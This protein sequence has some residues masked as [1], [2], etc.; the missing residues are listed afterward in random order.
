MDSCCEVK[1]W[2]DALGYEVK[3]MEDLPPALLRRLIY[4]FYE[5]SQMSSEQKA[6][7]RCYLEHGSEEEKEKC[8]AL[9]KR[10]DEKN[11]VACFE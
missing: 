5:L 7:P 9:H 2:D 8:E 11:E 4:R 6:K 3:E 10:F 1:D